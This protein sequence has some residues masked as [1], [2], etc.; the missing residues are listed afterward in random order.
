[1]FATYNGKTEVTAQ[2]LDQAEYVILGASHVTL[3]DDNDHVR[4][5]STRPDTGLGD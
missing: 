4:Q 3:G 1:M 2:P 5:L